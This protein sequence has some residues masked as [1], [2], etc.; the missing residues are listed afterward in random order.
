MTNDQEIVRDNIGDNGGLI[1]E[2][3]E[4]RNGVVIPLGTVHGGDD[5]VAGEDGGADAGK[6]GVAGGGGS[7]V[8]VAGAN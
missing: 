4:E 2:K 3:L 1:E 8:E 5:G 6:D 7:V